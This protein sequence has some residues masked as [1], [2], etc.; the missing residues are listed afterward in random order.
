MDIFECEKAKN[1][2]KIM[3]NIPSQTFMIFFLLILQHS[4]YYIQ[5][6]RTM[7]TITNLLLPYYTAF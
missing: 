5:A 7:I 4:N 2:K 1:K 6:L 3:E